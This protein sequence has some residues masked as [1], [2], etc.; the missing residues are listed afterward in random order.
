MAAESWDGLGGPPG[1]RW[2]NRTGATWYQLVGSLRKPCAACLRLHGR[3]SPRPWPI[4]LHPHCE[5]EPWEVAPGAEAPLVFG[6]MAGLMPRLG[7]PGQV[8]VVGLPSWWLE[9][10]G[11]VGWSDLFDG[12]GEVRD[13]DLVVR[14]KALTLEPLRRAGVAGDVARRAAW[15]G[16][17]PDDHR[18]SNAAGDQIARNQVATML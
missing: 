18:S 15:L 8:R 9:R 16:L 3:V 1:T 7:G 4:P 11:L 17:P 14:R 2:R 13:F 6:D 10:A 5:C 12:N